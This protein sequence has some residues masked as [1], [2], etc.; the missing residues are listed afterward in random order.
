MRHDPSLTTP[1]EIPGSKP[2]SICLIGAGPGARDLLTLRA[3]AR[4]AEADIVF[5]DRLVDEGVL[6]FTRPGAERVYVGKAVGACAWPQERINALIVAHA[7]RG[8]R[9]VRL[10]SG[11][12]GIFGRAGEE[13]AA[14][15]AHGIPVEVVPGITAACAAAASAGRSLTERGETDT[16]ILTT[17]QARAGAPLPDCTRHAQ[18]GTTLAFYMA[19]AQG[20]RI[21]DGLTAQ[22]MPGDAPVT[23]AVEVSKAGE[24]IIETSLACLPDDLAAHRI[25]GCA[26][27][28]VSWPKAHAGDAPMAKALTASL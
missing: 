14:A 8:R 1:A 16:L 6:D 19:V 10:K 24:R 12:P 3:V 13:I 2:A 28:I 21:R 15:S 23:V 25:T 5:F 11:D 17:G 26:T 22:G 27:L 20:A 4:L 7:L 9:V 18:P